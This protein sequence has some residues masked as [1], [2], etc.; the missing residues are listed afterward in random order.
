MSSDQHA[1]AQVTGVGSLLLG[2][3][4]VAMGGC[5]WLPEALPPPVRY[6]PLYLVVPAGICAIVSGIN[7]LRVKSGVA[8]PARRRA[9]A[10]TALGAVAVVVPVGVVVWALAVLSTMEG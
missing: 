10:G 7:V 8:A 5:P 9:W 3:G 4:A 1:P 2:F 6:F